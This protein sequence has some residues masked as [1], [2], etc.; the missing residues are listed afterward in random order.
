MKD[1]VI[2][3]RRKASL[4]ASCM[5]AACMTGA[6][7]RAGG[8]D[9]AKIIIVDSSQLPS[10]WQAETSTMEYMTIKGS[11]DLR[12]ACVEFGY[13]IEANGK[14][15]SPLRV[16]AL[17]T[18]ARTPRSDRSLEFMPPN[19][20]SAMPHFRYLL[21]DAPRATYSSISLAIFGDRFRDTLSTEQMTALSTSLRA[22]C[23]FPNL[24]KRL[25]EGARKPRRME[26][27]PTLE[28]LAKAVRQ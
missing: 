4:A 21:D 20:Q 23:H 22:A 6:T 11:G 7:A 14:V 27:L 3:R 24:G 8:D 18:D 10:V 28:E 5:L 12:Y 19:M 26:D 13:L 25:S 2:A 9:A 16:L 1:S 15:T 17:R